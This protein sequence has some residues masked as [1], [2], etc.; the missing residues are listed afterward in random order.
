MRLHFPRSASLGLLVLTGL[1]AA[2]VPHA[3]ADGPTPYPSKHDEA[4]W[5]G[6]GPIRLM[7]W[8][9]GNRASF[10]K[11]RER[12]RG[13]VV[14]VGSS[15]M[16]NW[17]NL[18]AAFPG[19]KVANRGIGGDVS[20]GLLFRFK[21]DVLDLEPRA[22]V[23]AIGSNDLSAHTDPAV[24]IENVAAIVDLARAHNP[25]LPIVL[26]PVAPREN[27]KAPLKPGALDDYNA[28]IVALGEQKNAAVPD[29]RAA[30]T[31][32]DGRQILEYFG[33]DRMHLS[34]AGYEKLGVVIGAE[35]KKLGV[36]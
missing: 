23:L 16:G 6:K 15:M 13:A 30:F 11:H 24:V 22:L 25:S 8:M 1:L 27:P 12:D 4:A 17:K 20:R 32:P 3:R 28:R 36:N 21:E 18:A 19:L 26:C 29:L 31:T 7:E 35:L 33:S 9:P 34:P 14:F 5:P 10:W 2:F